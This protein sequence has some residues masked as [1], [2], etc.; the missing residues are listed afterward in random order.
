[1]ARNN[2]IPAYGRH[3]GRGLARVIIDGKH[4]Y[5]GPYG[6]DESKAKYEQLV[7]KFLTDR[8][9]AEMK[10]RVE[11][12]T[13]LRVVE[14]I[15]AYLK[16][17]RGYFV[18]AGRPTAEY[19]HIYTTLKTV[20]KRCGED[21]MCTFGPLKVKAIREDWIKAN[22]VRG[23]INKRVGRICRMVKWGVSEQLVDPSILQAL[24]AI[25]GLKKGRSEAKEGKKV[26]PVPEA[27]VDAVRPHVS[28][29]IWA[30]IELQ[31]FSG[32]RPTETCVMRTIDIN[33]AGKIWEYRPTENKMEHLD[34]DRVIQLGPKAQEILREWIKPNVEAFLFSP[35]ESMEERWADQ[36]SK[37]KSPVQPS[38]KSR[39]TKK[40]IRTPGERY[41]YRSYSRAIRK[42]CV[43]AGVPHW[44][45]NQIRHLVLTKVRRELGLEASQ[46]VGGHSRAD[47]TQIYAERDAELARAA[48][49]KLG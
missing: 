4:V 30:M 18:K 14:L 36:R 8:A 7:R 31:R 9:A 33:M 12:S 38:Q 29:Q 15:S 19:T 3:A 46:V 47:V 5:L 34:R 1:M 23:Q 43:L 32:M 22:L 28:R 27:F 10:A 21:L 41:T 42:A 48:M 39:K 16:F 49:E 45:P 37:R 13:D 6:S 11:I 24:K 2:G 35:K 17:A 20:E 25:E 26:L 44:A 40:P